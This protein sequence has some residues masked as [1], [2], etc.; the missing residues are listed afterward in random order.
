MSSPNASPRPH[1]PNHRVV[2]LQLPIPL[3]LKASLGR[4]ACGLKWAG[5]PRIV[6]SRHNFTSVLAGTRR[7]GSEKEV[8]SAEPPDLPPRH[9]D[10][11]SISAYQPI[12]FTLP[13]P[14]RKASYRSR[15]SISLGLNNMPTG[16][17]LDPERA[18]GDGSPTLSDDSEE[19]GRRGWVGGMEEGYGELGDDRG[20]VA[21]PWA[22]AE[23]VSYFF[24]KVIAGNA[25][26]L[27]DFVIAAR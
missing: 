3:F 14:N 21:R 12:A 11:H 15:P 26:V 25:L 8:R 2:A 4:N 13:V 27:I 16:L 24:F 17:C 19:L 5:N 7:D 9:A 20:S 22:N 10:R 1:S 23:D 6:D 18:R